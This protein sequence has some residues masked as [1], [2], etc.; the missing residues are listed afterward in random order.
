[1]NDVLAVMLTNAACATALVLALAV[2]FM[3]TAESNEDPYIWLEEV[4]GEK[5]L[6][7]VEEQN[8]DTLKILEA[9]PNF[10]EGRDLERVERI[11]ARLGDRFGSI[12]KRHRELE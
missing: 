1:M 5:P 2:P 6:A 11:V 12:V 7:W 9:V 10:S 4:D 8:K 3:A